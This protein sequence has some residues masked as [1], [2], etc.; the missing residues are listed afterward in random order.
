MPQK[1]KVARI[2]AY[3]FNW[4]PHSRPIE[5]YIKT[6]W[7]C[8]R[9]GIR[10]SNKPKVLQIM[11]RVDICHTYDTSVVMKLLTLCEDDNGKDTPSMG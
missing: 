8:R 5:F 7:E 3:W 6:Y 2:P 1:C 9:L 4:Y 10:K 11:Y